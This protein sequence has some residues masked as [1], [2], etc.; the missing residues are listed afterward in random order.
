V[1]KVK[2]A[3][4]GSKATG[5]YRVDCECGSSW[6]GQGEMLG[7]VSYS[8]ALP[9]A[10]CVVHRRLEHPDLSQDI[11]FSARFSDWLHSYWDAANIREMSRLTTA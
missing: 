7:I 4:D 3:I 10:E 1:A 9:I 2:I 8:P 11:R 5:R 6:T